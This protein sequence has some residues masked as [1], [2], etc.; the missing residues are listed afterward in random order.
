MD[1]GTEACAAIVSRGAHTRCNPLRHFIL[2]FGGAAPPPIKTFRRR[3]GR[4]RGGPKDR[5]TSCDCAVRAGTRMVWSDAWESTTVKGPQ[6]ATATLSGTT[7]THV[8][9]PS[10]FSRLAPNDV[11]ADC[12]LSVAKHGRDPNTTLRAPSP[13]LRIPAGP[14]RASNELATVKETLRCQ[15]EMTDGP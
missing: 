9:L 6:R 1:S 14:S 11:I 12:N 7:K 5:P 3:Q 8:T 2:Y 10:E 15:S 13:S 4:I